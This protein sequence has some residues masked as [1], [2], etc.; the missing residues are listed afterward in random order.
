M[1]TPLTAPGTDG[2]RNKKFSQVLQS[3]MV[4]HKSLSVLWCVQ[5]LRKF[6]FGLVYSQLLEYCVL[7]GE[8]VCWLH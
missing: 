5:F 8:K 1:L 7:A 3:N 4:E 2:T 6:F